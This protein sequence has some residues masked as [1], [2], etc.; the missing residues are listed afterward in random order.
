MSI[1][2]ETK[3]LDDASWQAWV[4]KGRVKEKLRNARYVRLAKWVAAVALLAA[5]GL[6]SYLGQYDIALRFIASIGAI[7]AMF[8]ALYGRQYTFA[9]IFAALVLLYNP[10]A[11]VFG[12]SGDWQRALV[13]LSAMPFLGSLAWLDKRPVQHA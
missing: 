5:A 3:V 12:F 9:A 10:V 13:V 7:V 8:Q 1:V 6:W 11:P 2:I 4:A